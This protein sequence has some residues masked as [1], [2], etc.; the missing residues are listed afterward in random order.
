MEDRTEVIKHE[1]EEKRADLTDKLQ[2]LERKVTDEL[3]SVKDTVTESVENVTE[4]VTES[5]TGTIDSVKEAFDIPGYVREHPWLSVGGAV[6]A[7]YLAHEL[8]TNK[9]PVVSGGSSGNGHPQ[10]NQGGLF[11]FLG[12]RFGEELQSLERYAA[13]AALG[14]VGQAIKGAAPGEAGPIIGQVID[15]LSSALDDSNPQ[16]QPCATQD[17]AA[18]S[19]EKKPG[20]TN[21]RWQTEKR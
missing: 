11:S 4:N 9:I 7:G 8:L 12:G 6:V 21:M 2:T 15:R 18:G 19:G 17:C 14:L 1:M 13:R 3:L 5:I 16:S 20:T 10:A